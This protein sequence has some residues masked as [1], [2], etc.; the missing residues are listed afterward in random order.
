MSF[1]LIALICYVW[2]SGECIAIILTE[3]T[4]QKHGPLLSVYCIM[5]M[6]SYLSPI[7]RSLLVF[8]T[9]CDSFTT[10]GLRLGLFLTCKT[11]AALRLSHNL[12]PSLS[13]TFSSSASLTLDLKHS[14]ISSNTHTGKK[15]YQ[16]FLRRTQRGLLSIF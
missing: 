6:T 9:R 7:L 10:A 11:A 14:F 4:Q 12:S 3:T 1:R 13:L 2:V 8:P 16:A 5:G 15:L